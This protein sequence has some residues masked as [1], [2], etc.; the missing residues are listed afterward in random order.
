M[1][2]HKVKGVKMT[3]IEDNGVVEP[4][5]YLIDPKKVDNWEDLQLLLSVVKYIVWDDDPNYNVVKHL[6]GDVY[7]GSE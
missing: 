6:T 7:E 3:P 1:E 2:G 5:A 4:V